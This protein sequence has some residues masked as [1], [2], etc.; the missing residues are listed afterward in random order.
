M[1]TAKFCRV[2]TLKKS[3]GSL[4]QHFL[5]LCCSLLLTMTA[6]TTTVMTASVVAPTDDTLVD[7]GNHT[8]IFREGV[9]KE[10]SKQVLRQKL[11][12]LRHLVIPKGISP[13]YLDRL[14]PQL[15]KDFD[16]QEVVY[17]GG[18][19]KVK[20]WKISCY[21]E[22]MEAGVPCTNPN[23]KLLELFRP[24]LDTC[25]NLFLEWYRQQHACN[26]KRLGKV[27]RSCKRLMTFIT[28]Y[29]P[30]P[31]EQA[32]LKVCFRVCV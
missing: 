32:L 21:L 7:D 18:I 30:A 4:L 20:H 9:V 28:R 8:T 5:L 24:L 23:L 14:V 22:V 1:L 19:A 25:N 15:L 10:I 26:N 11:S 17:N 16:P 29:T 3:P 6:T 27:K 13:D 31:G 2:E 12:K